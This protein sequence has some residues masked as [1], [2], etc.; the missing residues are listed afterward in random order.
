MKWKTFERAK[1]VIVY[2]IVAAVLTEM[3]LLHFGTVNSLGWMWSQ[4]I[5]SQWL[6]SER[7]EFL[8]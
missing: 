6:W 7:T 2:G 8:P 5:E 4:H 3:N 1:G